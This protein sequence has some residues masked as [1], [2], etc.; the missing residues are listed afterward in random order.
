MDRD[1]FRTE[2]ALIRAEMVADRIWTETAVEGLSTEVQEVRGGFHDLSEE[3]R[4]F[5]DRMD[6]KFQQVDRRFD[7]MAANFAETARQYRGRTRFVEERFDRMLR[8]VDSRMDTVS[9]EARDD[10]A[11]LRRRVERLEAE[12]GPA[13]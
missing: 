3:F 11:D 7:L 9:L 10:V 12:R 1:E 4:R 6:Q 8:A 2:M 5:V 13:A